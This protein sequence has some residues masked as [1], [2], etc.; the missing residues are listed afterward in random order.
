MA[1]SM[2]VETMCRDC[3][4]VEAFAPTVHDAPFRPCRVFVS[5]ERLWVW[6][7][8]VAAPLPGW[9]T[10]QLVFEARLTEEAPQR[11]RGTGLCYGFS[12]QTDQGPVHVT[13]MSGCGCGSPLKA[14]SAPVGW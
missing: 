4:P 10:P 14:L 8:K 13:R 12:L 9:F 1:G 3:H 5:S 11:D 2:I 6:E 7:A